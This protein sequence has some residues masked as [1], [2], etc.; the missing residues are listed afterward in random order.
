EFGLIF[1]LS[2]IWPGLIIGG[3]RRETSAGVILASNVIERSCTS[4]EENK[5]P[6]R[7]SRV[8]GLI[9]VLTLVS[10]ALPQVGFAQGFNLDARR[11]G[12]GGAGYTNNMA[13][14]VIAEHQPYRVIPLPLGIFQLLD[15]RKFFDPNDPEFDPA[16][17]IEYAGNPLHFTLDR[18]SDSAGHEFVNDLVN[19]RFSRDLNAYRGFSPSPEIKAGGLFSPSWGKTIRVSGDAAAG[20]SHGIYVGVGPYVS[21]GTALA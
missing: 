13:S 18:N 6:M 5:V 9:I 19:A 11:I 14:K 8:I 4:A 20:K 21:L 15:N 17:A 12:L 3:D 2:I 1:L 16:R 7:L 10:S